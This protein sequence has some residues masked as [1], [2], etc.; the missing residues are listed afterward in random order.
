MMQKQSQKAFLQCFI[1]TAFLSPHLASSQE[2]GMCW[3]ISQLLFGEEVYR[4]SP[5]SQAALTEEHLQ[6]KAVPILFCAFAA[7]KI[8]ELS[9]RGKLYFF[10][11]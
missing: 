8:N 11:E 7:I 5:S 3:M 6:P 10:S 2:S 4:F 9:W 1:D